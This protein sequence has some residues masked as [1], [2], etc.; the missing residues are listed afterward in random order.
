MKSSNVVEVF[1]FT[2]V[3]KISLLWVNWKTLLH[4]QASNYNI[5][6]VGGKGCRECVTPNVFIPFGKSAIFSNHSAISAT[7]SYHLA[8]SA[9]ALCQMLA[10]SV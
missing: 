1:H 5:D 2:P 6:G 8:I 10:F 9:T 4:V 3:G 7:F